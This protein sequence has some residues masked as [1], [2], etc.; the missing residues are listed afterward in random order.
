MLNTRRASRV[1]AVRAS[2]LKW[3]VAAA[4][5]GMLLA[6]GMP[7]HAIDD[8][9]YDY[10][11]PYLQFD[12]KTGKFVPVDRSKGA[13]SAQSA[14]KHHELLI[15]GISAVTLTVL[16]GLLILRYQSSRRNLAGRRAVSRGTEEIRG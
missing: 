9:N 11:N 1:I 16:G 8:S 10:G 13:G 14:Q 5:C 15:V 7:A 12:P 6:V 4:V 2:R 3:L